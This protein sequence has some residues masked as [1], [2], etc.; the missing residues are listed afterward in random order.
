M[1]QSHLP[2]LPFKLTFKRGFLL[3]TCP[4]EHQ[5]AVR[6][7]LSAMKELPIQLERQGSR[8]IFNVHQDIWS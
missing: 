5:H 7:R 6:E 2:R 3:V 8:V 1:G 4:L